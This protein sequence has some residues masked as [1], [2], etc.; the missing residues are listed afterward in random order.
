MV[1]GLIFGCPFDE[2]VDNCPFSEIRKL[3][4]GARIDG[5][6]NLT[7]AEKAKYGHHHKEC[8][9]RRETIKM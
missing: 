6:R 2:E 5:L 9:A 8:L 3:S 1:E 4:P 7:H